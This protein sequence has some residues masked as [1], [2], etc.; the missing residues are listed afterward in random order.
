MSFDKSNKTMLIGIQAVMTWSRIYFTLLCTI[1]SMVFIRPIYQV[2][3]QYTNM[4]QI[5]LPSS[6]RRWLV[7]KMHSAL[8]AKASLSKDTPLLLFLLIFLIWAAMGLVQ[9]TLTQSTGPKSISG[10]LPTSGFAQM[11]VPSSLVT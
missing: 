2:L 7:W 1:L 4:Y 8:L 9:G 5:V 11:A 6:R 10:F 3:G